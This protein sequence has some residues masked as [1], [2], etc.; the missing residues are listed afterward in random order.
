MTK[1][2]RVY[3]IEARHTNN[4]SQADGYGCWDYV[5]EWRADSAD[6]ALDEWLDEQKYD[7]DRFERTGADS[8]R[9]GNAEFDARVVE[10]A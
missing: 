8:Y 6:E 2:A 9:V 3:T 5:G 1:E 4:P 7:D 10:G